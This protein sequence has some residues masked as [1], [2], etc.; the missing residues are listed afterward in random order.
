MAYGSSLQDVFYLNFPSWARD[1]SGVI[2]IV[3]LLQSFMLQA[4]PIYTWL[5]EIVRSK[6]EGI[7]ATSFPSPGFSQYFSPLPSPSSTQAPLSP[8]S[9]ASSLIVST[10]D[11]LEVEASSKTD[12]E[13]SGGCK[14]EDAC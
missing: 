8:S 1:V 7:L 10:E 9:S 6:T 12:I 14:L 5:E 4:F 13:D 2:L 3:V 11:D